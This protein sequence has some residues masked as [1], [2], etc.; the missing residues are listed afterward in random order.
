MGG[1]AVAGFQACQIAVSGALNGER[2][3]SPTTAPIA[4]GLDLCPLLRLPER[5]DEVAVTLREIISGAD[6]FCPCPTLPVG[7]SHNPRPGCGGA[8][9]AQTNT[10]SNANKHRLF[11][12]PAA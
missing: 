11:S 2:C 1:A 10:G 5:Q 12:K 4:S 7:N 9:I 6:A 8:P 3:A